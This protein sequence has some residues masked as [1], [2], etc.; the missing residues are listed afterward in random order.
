MW[1]FFTDVYPPLNNGHSPL[2]PP[3]WWIRI[4]EGPPPPPE[5]TEDEEP[6][7]LPVEDNSVPI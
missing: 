2:D 1:Y 7:D 6:A 3:A 4:F 5:P